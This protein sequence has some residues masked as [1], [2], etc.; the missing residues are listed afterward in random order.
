MPLPENASESEKG[1]LSSPQ[2]CPPKDSHG[3]QWIAALATSGGSAFVIIAAGSP[4]R[5][6]GH[7]T[8]STN[9]HFYSAII[10]ILSSRGTS[11]KYIKPNQIKLIDF[12]ETWGS[13]IQAHS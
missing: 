6:Q 1:T 7:G 2:P 10:F 8:L 11:S 3:G 9:M 4:K 5:V 12:I 13:C